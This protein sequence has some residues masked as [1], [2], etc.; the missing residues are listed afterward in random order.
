MRRPPGDVAA[1]ALLLEAGA[2]PNARDVSGWT[3][4]HKAAGFNANPAVVGALLDAGADVHAR[5]A[6]GW[7]PLH[8]AAWRA[9]NPAAVAL[10]A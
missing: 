10:L 8:L 7:T 3:P 5:D 2:D 9:A 4:L 6:D 1:V